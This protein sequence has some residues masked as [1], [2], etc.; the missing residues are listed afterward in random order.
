MLLK[1]KWKKMG[2]CGRKWKNIPNFATL[3]HGQK[4]DWIFRHT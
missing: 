2:E 3:Y 4:D 1:N